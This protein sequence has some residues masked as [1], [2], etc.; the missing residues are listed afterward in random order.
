MRRR[1]LL[2]ALAPG[3]AQAQGSLDHLFRIAIF[4]VRWPDGRDGAVGVLP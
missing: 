3:A 1:C 2:L 4:E